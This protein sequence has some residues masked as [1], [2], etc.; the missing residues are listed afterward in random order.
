MTDD[1]AGADN[2]ITVLSPSNSSVASCNAGL[3]SRTRLN[4]TLL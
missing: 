4:G 1:L 2:R 3:Q